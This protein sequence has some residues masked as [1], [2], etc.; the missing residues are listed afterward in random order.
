MFLLVSTI[1]YFSYPEMTSQNQIDE[2]I[3]S[4]FS[5]DSLIVRESIN[6]TNPISKKHFYVSQGLKDNHKGID[7]VTEKGANVH[8]SYAGKVVHSGHDNIYGE[9]I[10]L[11]HKNNF[12]TFY[13]HLDSIFVKKHNFIKNNEI[14]GLVGE[15]GQTSGPH[16]HFE[17]WNDWE[18]SDPRLLI[19]EL[20]ERDVTK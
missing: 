20:K 12:Y 6:F 18:I 7:I 11:A 3:N 9:I 13:G 2:Y 14:I 19:N 16:L 5:S 17:I 10:I 15:T 1:I 8:A 4:K